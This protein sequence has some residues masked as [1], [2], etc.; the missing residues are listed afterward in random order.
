MIDRLLTGIEDDIQI[1]EKFPCSKITNESP[2]SCTFAIVIHNPSRPE[3]KMKSFDKQ[4]FFISVENK[5]NFS[6][7]LSFHVSIF[8]RFYEFYEW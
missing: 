5:M 3:S 6:F 2:T 8:V 7:E 1:D 4:F